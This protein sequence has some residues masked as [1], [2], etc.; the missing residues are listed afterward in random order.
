MRPALVLLHMAQDVPR[1]QDQIIYNIQRSNSTVLS[2]PAKTV[3]LLGHSPTQVSVPP[4]G[5]TLMT[6]SVQSCVACHT[7]TLDEAA[8]G[9]S[10]GGAMC[11]QTLRQAQY[12]CK[13]GRLGR[14]ADRASS[15]A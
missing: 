8:L 2:D 4:Q 9:W 14:Q 6:F 3:N 12:Q 11:C 13:R 15:P 5:S 1:Q 7:H 10:A